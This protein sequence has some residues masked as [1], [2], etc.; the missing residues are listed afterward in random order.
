MRYFQ[1]DVREEPTEYGYMP[2][3]QLYLLEG[4]DKPRPIVI[5][6]PAEAMKAFIRKRTGWCRSITRQG[7]TPRFCVTV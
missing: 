4:K 3:L 2:V 1:V 7:F 6:A 5:I